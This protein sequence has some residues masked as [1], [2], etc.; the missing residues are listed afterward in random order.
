MFAFLPI[1]FTPPVAYDPVKT[2]L[3]ESE[4]EVELRTNQSQAPELSI[5]TGLFFRFCLRL[6]QRRFHLIES[7]RVILSRISVLIQTLSV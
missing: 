1:S 5:V 3:S 6:R 7:D 2:R 4:A